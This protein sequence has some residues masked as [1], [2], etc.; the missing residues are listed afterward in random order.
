MQSWP[1]GGARGVLSSWGGQFSFLWRGVLLPS[2][3]GVCVGGGSCHPGT[4]RLRECCTS[5]L[6]FQKSG[7]WPHP[8]LGTGILPWG[9]PKHKRWFWV[10]LYIWA[11][12]F[13][14]TSALQTGKKNKQNKLVK[15]QYYWI[16]NV[17][18]SCLFKK[19]HIRAEP[20]VSATVLLRSLHPHSTPK[21]VCVCICARA[22]VVAGGHCSGICLLTTPALRASG[23][24]NC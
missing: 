18:L 19:T 23:Q 10:C 2:W 14:K 8:S 13:T 20:S 12:F 5:L 24:D 17:N 15:K 1:G 6:E 22:G 16:K 3:A 9:L 21:P 7:H 4:V 11:T